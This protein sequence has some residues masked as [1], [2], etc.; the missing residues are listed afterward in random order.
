M[1]VKL[2]YNICLYVLYISLFS[3]MEL[4]YQNTMTIVTKPRNLGIFHDQ[5]LTTQ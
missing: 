5:S 1:C 4:I 3:R 2:M